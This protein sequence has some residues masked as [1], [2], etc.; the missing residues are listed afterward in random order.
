M[1]QSELLAS[2]PTTGRLHTTAFG[3]E[4]SG[5]LAL[6]QRVSTM[7]SRRSVA[8]DSR[9]GM[10]VFRMQ[11]TS[12][13][14]SMQ[15]A[16]EIHLHISWNSPST[17]QLLLLNYG[18][19]IG[20]QTAHGVARRKVIADIQEGKEQCCKNHGNVGSISGTKRFFR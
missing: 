11:C 1:I 8:G 9:T 4:S 3:A 15:Y 2:L 17:N 16:A 19:N 13:T 5:G 18:L 20:M 7:F 14:P 6:T 10:N 12:A